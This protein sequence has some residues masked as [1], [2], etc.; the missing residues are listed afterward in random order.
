MASL[1]SH[2]RGLPT[3]APS[4]PAIANQVLLS[5]DRSISTL[6]KMKG[7]NYSRYAD[8]LTFSGDNEETLK[9][10]PFVERIL[11]KRVMSSM[12]RRPTYSEKE[13]GNASQDS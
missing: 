9:M 12:I 6:A 3:G 13:E 4:S 7:V 5:T 10:I 1:C 8:D 2:D 11:R